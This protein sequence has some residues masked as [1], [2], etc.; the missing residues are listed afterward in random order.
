[1][2]LR[3]S[4]VIPPFERLLIHI[5]LPPVDSPNKRPCSR[6]EN[7]IKPDTPAIQSVRSRLR[8]LSAKRETWDSSKDEDEGGMH[9][10]M[11]LA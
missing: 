8:Q 3:T 5:L 6:E 2:I 11:L 4:Q 9:L 10:I 7:E 1:M